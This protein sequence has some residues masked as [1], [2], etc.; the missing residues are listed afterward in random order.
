MRVLVTGATG[1]IGGA[2]TRRLAA[3]GHSVVGLVRSDASAAK[4]TD[5]G[6]QA[7]HGDLADPASVASAAQGVDAVVH[8]ASP[9]DQNMATYDVAA[10]RAIIDA[11]R[12]TSKRF[13]YTSGCLVYGPT[14][15]TPATEDSPLHPVE[16]VQFRQALEAEILGA[17][18]DSVHPVV[19]RPA[20]VYGNRSGT[21]MM[22]YDAA[23]EHGAARYVGDGQNR[24]TTVHTDDLADLYLLALEKASAASIFN[25]AHGPAIPLVEI[26]RAAS[27]AAGT[28]GRVAEWPLDEARQAL[29]GF[30]DAIACD[31]LVSGELAERKL[32]WNPSRHSIIDELRSYAAVAA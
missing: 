9:S 27:E 26:A 12:G 2:V 22:M 28:E 7:M 25:G 3:A 5:L 14:G 6:Y 16:L 21:A 11:L 32:G 10:T 18:A 24:W 4:L 30:A 20:W 1:L 15:D 17:V 29:W 19:I 8:A 13:V 23:K 31:Q